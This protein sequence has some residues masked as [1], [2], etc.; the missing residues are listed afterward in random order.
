MTDQ[1]ALDALGLAGAPVTFVGGM[2]GGS[3]I[4]LSPKFP[5]YWISLHLGR[6]NAERGE[7][8]LLAWSTYPVTR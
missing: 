5:G 2:G 7:R 8:H 1:Q 6:A 3:R 4:V